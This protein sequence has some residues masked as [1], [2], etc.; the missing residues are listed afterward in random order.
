MNDERQLLD[1][2]ILLSL[3]VIEKVFLSLAKATRRTLPFKSLYS[4]IS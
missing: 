3:L 4:N 1:Q 2:T